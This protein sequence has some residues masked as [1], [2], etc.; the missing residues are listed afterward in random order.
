[1]YISWTHSE[2]G[3]YK[4]Q[5]PMDASKWDAAPIP[6]ATGKDV[7]KQN[8]TFTSAYLINAK[9][10]NAELAFKVYKEIFTSEDFLVGY[11]EGG[12]GVSIIPDI[13][14]KANLSDEIKDKK[15]F[16]CRILMQFFH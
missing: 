12:Y 14:E 5:F 1:M 2:P 10:P 11:Q 6:T 13:V 8:I 16:R 15:G 3:V 4:D 7:G 9:S